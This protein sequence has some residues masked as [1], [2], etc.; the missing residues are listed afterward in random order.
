[1]LANVNTA[2]PKNV[3][4]G[5][6]CF[7]FY[8]GT[9]AVVKGRAFCYDH[10]Y[11]TTTT[12]ETATD[13]WGARM[14]IVTK[15]DSTNNLYFA[16]V[17]VRSQ[18]ANSA[19]QWVELWTPGSTCLIQAD[20]ATVIGTTY[21]TAEC[22]VDGIWFKPGFHGR[23]TAQVLETN[24]VVTGTTD[25]R[26]AEVDISGLDGTGVYT[27]LT[28]GLADVAGF[29]DAVVGDRVVI[30]A[31]S[32]TGGT[33]VSTPMETTIATKTSADAVILTD[34]I[35]AANLQ[36]V[37]Y[38]VVRGYPLVLA[39]LQDGPESGLCQYFAPIAAAD[40]QEMVGGVTFICAATLTA[41][42]GTF[43]LADGI[44]EGLLK[45]YYELGTLTTNNYVVTCTSAIQG[46]LH[47][48]PSTALATMT[49]DTIGSVSLLEWFGN[50]G[51]ATT[52]LWELKRNIAT[53]IA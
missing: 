33:A 20:L 48:T 38:Y 3:E 17:A 15:P 21:L 37:T 22:T 49:F 24:A 23:G 46:V 6:K 8:R 4:Q 18:P 39:S 36:S 16:G 52:G 25:T 26:A 44:R 29:T 51:P 7:A 5:Q 32:L 11:V 28:Q 13:P 30:L 19:G 41:A 42:D 53:V 43:T 27:A 12:G 50:L 14:K 10:D 34:A 35:N 47:A 40:T 1:M 45:G 31:G 9:E 2:V